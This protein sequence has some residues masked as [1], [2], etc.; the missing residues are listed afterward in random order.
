M[1]CLIR[2]GDPGF[3]RKLRTPGATAR[4]N[5]DGQSKP[6]TLTCNNISE[7]FPPD[8]YVHRTELT[9]TGARIDTKAAANRKHSLWRQRRNQ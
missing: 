8:G 7:A 1:Q 3:R 6:I 4:L 9:Q 5:G 2:E